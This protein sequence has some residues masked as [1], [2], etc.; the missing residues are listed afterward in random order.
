M[1]TPT[2]DFLRSQGRLVQGT[3]FKFISFVEG[4]ASVEDRMDVEVSVAVQATRKDFRDVRVSRIGWMWRFQL[5][6]KQVSTSLSEHVNNDLE[7]P[8]MVV[9]MYGMNARIEGRRFR[10]NRGVRRSFRRTHVHLMEIAQSNGKN[11]M[12]TAIYGYWDLSY[13]QVTC[14]FDGNRTIKREEPNGYCDL[15]IL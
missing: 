6:F 13:H 7:E 1:Q 3:D 5:P 12:D 4:C 14:A 11:L 15:W 10:V 8:N 9:Y 2:G